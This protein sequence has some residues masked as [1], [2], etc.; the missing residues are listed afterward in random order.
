MLPSPA[1]IESLGLKYI[2]ESFTNDIRVCSL[3]CMIRVNRVKEH[4][5]MLSPYGLLVDSRF[6]KFCKSH[7]VAGNERQ[8]SGWR[9]SNITAYIPQKTSMCNIK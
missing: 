8:C 1:E 5:A 3:L 7:T 9:T 4:Q 6:C 2:F